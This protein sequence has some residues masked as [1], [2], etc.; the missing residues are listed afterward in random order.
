MSDL[1]SALEVSQ[2]IDYTAGMI[3]LMSFKLGHQFDS[4]GDCHSCGDHCCHV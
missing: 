1:Q 2:W 4:D 3:A